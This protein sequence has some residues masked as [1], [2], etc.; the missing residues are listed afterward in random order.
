MD[1]SDPEGIYHE[2]PYCASV[3]GFYDYFATS[4]DPDEL[5]VPTT[6]LNGPYCTAYYP[7]NARWI[8]WG[9]SVVKKH[10]TC[11]RAV[12]SPGVIKLELAKRLEPSRFRDRLVARK[13]NLQM[14]ADAYDEI[15]RTWLGL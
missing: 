15:D 11:T 14:H 6:L 7:G 13:F 2:D 1:T 3:R 5:F 8:N 9:E 12:N 4:V 10:P